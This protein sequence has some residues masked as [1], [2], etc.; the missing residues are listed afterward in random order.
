MYICS[1]TVHACPT[2]MSFFFVIYHPLAPNF[3]ETAIW[4]LEQKSSEK[5]FN[6][7]HFTEFLKLENGLG[8]IFYF[9]CCC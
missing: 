4:D 7:V 8:Y 9:Y 2:G 6:R 5:N 1:T 3:C